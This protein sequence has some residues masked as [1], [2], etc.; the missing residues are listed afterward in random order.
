[1]HKK[2]ITSIVR[3]VLATQNLSKYV[4]YEKDFRGGD[5]LL[6]KAFMKEEGFDILRANYSEARPFDPYYEFSIKDLEF[7]HGQV[8][9]FEA[10]RGRDRSK[11]SDEC[12]EDLRIMEERLGFDLNYY[13]MK[14][15]LVFLNLQNMGIGS[16]LYVRAARAIAPKKAVL[17]PENCSQG[18]ITSPMAKRIWQSSNMKRRLVVQGETVFW[19]GN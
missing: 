1:M 19:G 18:G 14:G 12:Q 4:Y 13:Q 16:E 8:A 3:R 15:V 9:E 17:I 6:I 11:L 10:V 5:T 2:M 7:D